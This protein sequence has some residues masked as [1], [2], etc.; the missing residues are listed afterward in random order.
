MPA[1]SRG[2]QEA[3]DCRGKNPFVPF[4]V[5][6]KYGQNNSRQTDKTDRQTG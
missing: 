4:L 1:V 3:H 6:P 5:L 2:K